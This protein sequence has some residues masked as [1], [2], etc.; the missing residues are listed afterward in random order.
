MKRS[1]CVFAVA[2][3]PIRAVRRIGEL[4]R[5][6][7]PVHEMRDVVVALGYSQSL[8]A[9]KYLIDLAQDRLM[10]KK[11]GYKLFESIAYSHLPEAAQA[12]LSTIDPKIAQ[13]KMEIP[14]DYFA[15]E[16]LS[17]AIADLCRQHKEIETTVFELCNERL[18]DS[19]REIIANVI[20]KLSTS[21]AIIAGLKLISDKSK[22]PK[23][24]PLRRAIEHLLVKQV[25][26]P[27]HMGAYELEPQEDKEIR[28]RL[29]DMAID[30]RRRC[31]TAFELLGFIHKLRF[32]Y[33]KPPTEPRHPNLQRGKPWPLL[34]L[35]E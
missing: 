25:P 32:E 3:D 24:Y 26:V 30:D 19:Q 35:I 29:F 1:L 16:T 11:L 28:Y 5:K 17:Q 33:G 31:R 7:L 34:E 6:H 21:D 2:N 8:E 13:P 9:T 22:N 4:A 14:T 15:R 23:S 18:A 10:Y 27:W 12:L 20:E